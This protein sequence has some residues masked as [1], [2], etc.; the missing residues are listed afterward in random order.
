MEE[1]QTFIIFILILVITLL[2]IICINK[3]NMKTIGRETNGMEGFLDY[4]DVKTKTL[5]WC[6]KMQENGLLNSDQYNQCVS[7]FKDVSS[8]ASRSGIDKS[9]FGMGIDYSIY[10]T[11]K[12]NLSP[13]ATNDNSNTILL[14]NYNNQ[15]LACKADGTLYTVPDI[16]DPNINQKE[17][18]FTL[19]PINE[20][21][22]TILSPYGLFLVADNEFNAGFIGKSAGPLASWNLVPITDSLSTYGNINKVMIESIQ[23]PN[24]H[25]VYY[26]DTNTLQIENGRND[27]MMWMVQ[28]KSKSN[29][30]DINDNTFNTSQYFVIKENLLSRIKQNNLR[31]LVLSASTDTVNNFTNNIRSNIDNI[32]IYVENYLQNQQR[33]YNLSSIDYE[34]R[35]SSINNN[36]MIDTETKKNL[37]SN[38]PV[39]QGTN[40]STEAIN[41]VINDIDTYKNTILQYITTNGIIPLSQQMTELNKNDTTQPDY[42]KFIN[43]LNKEIQNVNNQINQNKTIMK[44]QKDTYNAINDDFNYQNQQIK[45]L[46]KIDSVASINVKLLDNYQL[47]KNYLSKLYPF[48]I[49]ILIFGII[50]LAYLT[51]LKFKNNVWVKYQE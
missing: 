18:Y 29:S 33:I 38:L 35:V 41:R 21:T 32:K 3:F 47:Q 25:L 48:I 46:D 5:N 7:S 37:I 13:S 42:D 6:N 36:S 4:Q 1:K 23:F 11:R 19:E 43:E 51:F 16:N 27:S 44:R 15:T 39:I 30:N 45:K 2:I 31:R 20:N 28:A 8:G 22:Y 24:F 14:T 49:L 9:R 12:T 10:N 34:T 50:Y 26:D 40:V 17:L